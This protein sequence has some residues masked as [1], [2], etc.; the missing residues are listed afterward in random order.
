V[1][2]IKTTTTWLRSLGAAGLMIAMAGCQGGDPTASEGER[3]G[4]DMQEALEALGAQVVDV[5]HASVPTFITGEL[6]LVAMTG[7]LSTADLDEV[8]AAISPV[9]RADASELVLKGSQTDLIG[10]RHLRFRQVKDG[11]D[12]FGAELVLHVRDGIVYSVNGS[13]RAD[14]K[15]PEAAELDMSDAITAALGHAANVISATAAEAPRLALHAAEGRLDLV[16]VVEVTGARADGTPV[17][18][19]I[20]VNAVDGSLAL[21]MPHIHSAKNREMHNLNHATSLPG[22]LARTEGG[23]ASADAVVNTNYDR[24]GSTYD[25]YSAL[26][27]RDSY[28][29]AGAKMISSVHYSNN[30]VNAYWNGVQMVYGDGDGVQASN[31]ANSMD[32]TA[33]ELTH[34][35]TETSSNLT[36]SGESGGLNESMSDVFGNVCEWYRDGQVVSANTWMVGED[37]WT[38]ATPNDALRYMANPSQDGGSLDYYPDYA[39]GIDV[40]Y[41]SGISNLAFYLLSQGGTHPTG[42]TST[43]VT[44]IGIAKA[45]QIFYRANTS[46][47]TASTTFEQAKT[48]TEQ[49]ATQLGY[50]AAEVASVTAAWQAVGVGIPV[51]PPVTTPLTNGTTVTGLSGGTGAKLYYTLEVPAGATSLSF[52]TTGG[53]GDADLYVRFGLAPTLS[54][55]D[56]RPYLG[57]NAETCTIANIQTGTYYVMLQGYSAFSGVS[58]TGTYGGGGGGGNVL[59][60][61]VGITISGAKNSMQTWTLAVPA[62]QPSVT[63]STNGGT[64][65]ITLYVKVGAAPTTNSY[66]CRSAAS[67]GNVTGNNETCTIANPAAGTWYVTPRG[68]SAYSGATLKGQY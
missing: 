21:R 42:K 30:Y 32:V 1:N 26:F 29:N 7:E 5:D 4:L 12:V 25:C 2:V 43:V 3:S 60:N 20:L 55:Y 61:G 24:L 14:L 68:T 54:A 48:A 34:A 23:A 6:G 36:Y 53:T 9:F 49:A 15:A 67:S 18:D 39:A 16:Y 35:V 50:T 19:T 62:G 44:G 38:P 51:P 56:C 27:G 11:L 31:L 40:H 63:F 52:T 22:P 47:F 45:A 57:G 41:S 17:S 37:I 46:I 65:N 28:N 8:L 13:A 64:G 59:S 66:T 58:L 10:D 33:H